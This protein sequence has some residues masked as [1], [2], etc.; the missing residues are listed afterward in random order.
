MRIVEFGSVRFITLR[1]DEDIPASVEYE[2]GHIYL[3]KPDGERWSM[4]HKWISWDEQVH[5]FNTEN[6]AFMH[7]HQL[8]S[9]DEVRQTFSTFD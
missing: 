2:G 9:R 8:Y 6:E 1:A 3:I 5:H 4:R 7:A